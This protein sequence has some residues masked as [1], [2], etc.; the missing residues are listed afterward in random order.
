MVVRLLCAVWLLGLSSWGWAAPALDLHTLTEGTA[1]SA[2]YALVEHGDRLLG[3][4][5]GGQ[6]VISDADKQQWRTIQLPSEQRTLLDV[7]SVGQALVAVGQEGAVYTSR[8]G[9]AWTASDSSTTARLFAVSMN[10]QGLAVAVGAFGAV[11]RS[12]DSG[13]SWQTV[14]MDWMNLLEEPYEPHIYD[15]HVDDTGRTT[16]VGE[17]GMVAQSADGLR[18]WVLLRKDDASL[19]AI[20]HSA[21]GRD[22]YAV[23]QAGE[24][25]HS[26][27]Q[28]RSWRR[29]ATGT[30]SILLNVSVGAGGDVLISG[31]RDCLW[32]SHQD[33]TLHPVISP[34][35]GERWY[36]AVLAAAD[37]RFYVA[38]QAGHI[39]SL[40]K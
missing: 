26:Q 36:S 20:A 12:T 30:E 37:A 28:G 17:F 31:L 32:Y 19:F 7:A 33:K 18:D 9:Q 24:F 39:V 40:T 3:V 27:D 29:I 10:H 13:K 16:I 6:I 25:I 2:T 15:V 34:V 22:I 5:A 11:L 38:G 23:G 14:T 4:G 1:H 8:D 35:L 21:D